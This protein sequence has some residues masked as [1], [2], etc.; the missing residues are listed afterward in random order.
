MAGDRLMQPVVK[1]RGL[2]PDVWS[3]YGGGTATLGQVTASSRLMR[4]VNLHLPGRNR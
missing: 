2:T 4:P 3:W 1:N